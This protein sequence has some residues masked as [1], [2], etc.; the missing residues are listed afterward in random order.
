MCSFHVILYSIIVGNVVSHPQGMAVSL[1]D[2][3]NK[4]QKATLKAVAAW[5]HRTELSCKT[6]P[7]IAPMENMPFYLELSMK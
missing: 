7:G 2:K 6:C 3:I 4:V 5:E 1:G